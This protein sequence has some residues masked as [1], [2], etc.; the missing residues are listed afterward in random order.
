MIILGRIR[1]FDLLFNILNGDKTLEIEIIIH[2]RKLLHSRPGQNLLGLHHGDALFRRNQIL[3]GHTLFDFL[4]IIFL[5]F[6][7][8]IGDNPHQFPS[9]CDGNTGDTELCHQLVRIL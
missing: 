3:G 7:V 2:D 4:G 8:T 1:V 6:K 9:L 5:K